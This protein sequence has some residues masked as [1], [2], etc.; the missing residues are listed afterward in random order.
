LGTL[1][2]FG[3]FFLVLPEIQAFETA[4]M[5]DIFLSLGVESR[6]P[7]DHCPADMTGDF[8]SCS[9]FIQGLSWVKSGTRI[10]ADLSA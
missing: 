4:E 8:F 3:P 5:E 7:G 6:R 10:I 9:F 1:S 2:A